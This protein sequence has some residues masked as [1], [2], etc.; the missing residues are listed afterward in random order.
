MTFTFA[1][2]FWPTTR[3]LFFASW[4][5]LVAAVLL[6]LGTSFYT[7]MMPL[8]IF[9][10]AMLVFGVLALADGMGS[11]ALGQT[12]AQVSKDYSSTARTQLATGLVRLMQPKFALIVIFISALFAIFFEANLI[13]IIA[14]AA[15]YSFTEPWRICGQTLLIM[16][17][18][19][20]LTSFW[21]A[22][23]AALTL[24]IT[25]ALIYLTH[26]SVTSLLGGA[27]LGR[28]V[29][30]TSFWLTV[31]GS[32]AIFQPDLVEARKKC[33]R[34]MHFA[35]GVAL[36][37][38]LG[39]LGAY[40]DRYIIGGLNGMAAA[41]VF[42]ALGGI[43]G[44]PFG[45]VSSGLTNYFRADLLDK[46]AGQAPVHLTPLKTWALMALCIGGIGVIFF[47]ILSRPI[48]SFFL[49]ISNPGPDIIAVIALLAI[50]QCILIIAHAFEN[51]ALALG[52]SGYLLR[53]QLVT[54]LLGLSF[55]AC[56]AW[57]FGLVGAAAG[58][59]VNETL[60][61]SG[62]IWLTRRL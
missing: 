37:A 40:A 13:A 8:N 28:S 43:V 6:L 19:Y 27:V 15:L 24:C 35:T 42:A 34:A 9:G 18:Q 21:T 3:R 44:R 51:Q 36:M 30:A 12:I 60:R 62:C 23:E 39:W 31:F 46:V 26:S 10:Q 45:I 1:S 11:M 16:E 38:P 54:L 53:T 7:E 33:G 25:L 58:R 59:L 61:L 41:G 56:G 55:I 32:N 5:Q 20:G 48:A 4:G 57:L 50:S 47:V 14:L 2:S 29:I 52:R 22:S 17:R 49:N